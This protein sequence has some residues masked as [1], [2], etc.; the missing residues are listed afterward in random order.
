[1]IYAHAV[2]PWDAY[3]AAKASGYTG[4]V[5]ATARLPFRPRILQMDQADPCPLAPWWF[6]RSEMTL[7]G[8]VRFDLWRSGVGVMA[9]RSLIVARN[10]ARQADVDQPRAFTGFRIGQVWW[11]AWRIGTQVIHRAVGPLNAQDGTDQSMNYAEPRHDH[12]PAWVRAQITA[13]ARRGPDEGEVVTGVL[14]ADPCAPRAV[15]WAGFLPLDR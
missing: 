12:D 9:A 11:L 2:H 4:A 1:M 3:A 14:L 5:D 10:L 15:G 7:D 6:E 13:A 8:W